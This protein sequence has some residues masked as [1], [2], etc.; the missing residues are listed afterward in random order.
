MAYLQATSPK[1]GISVVA[2]YATDPFLVGYHIDHLST[3]TIR[4]S[5][6]GARAY[7]NNFEIVLPGNDSLQNALTLDVTTV[8]ALG[9]SPVLMSAA[10]P[11]DNTSFGVYVL[12]DS[13]GKNSTTAVIATGNDFLLDGY[14]SWRRVGMVQNNGGADTL[15]F[16]VQSG[17][18]MERKYLMSSAYSLL[19]S[20]NDLTLTEVNCTTGDG[21]CHPEFNTELG[22]HIEFTPNAAASIVDIQP[23]T[24]PVPSII[25]VRY[26]VAA[27]AQ[28]ITNIVMPS[29]VN[30]GNVSFFY[31][32]SS[33]SDSVDINLYSFEESM[34]LYA[35]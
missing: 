27:A 17:L 3:T 34:G 19:S 22:L 35:L 10:A 16:M 28:G 15:V 13:S 6:G 30:A 1:N 32:T 33:A 11:T 29:E 9:C 18:G 20:G 7:A 26:Q 4:L 12:G 14:D 23:S 25:P 31:Q 24:A 21:P 2:S 8:G 5:A